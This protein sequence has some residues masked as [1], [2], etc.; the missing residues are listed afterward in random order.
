MTAAKRPARPI[1]AVVTD[2]DGTLTDVRRRLDPRAIEMIHRLVDRKVPVLLATGNVLPVALGIYRSLGLSTPIVAENGGILYRPTSRGDRVERLAD[3]AVALRAYRR[4]VRAGLPVRRLFTDRWRE[5]E[6]ALDT[7]VSVLRIEE[8]LRGFPIHVEG[9]G[10]A[11][12]LMERGTG[13]LPAL[14]R[15][16]TPLRL[17]PRDCVILG[18]GDNDIEMLRAAGWSVSFPNASPGARAAAT[19]LTRSDYTGGFIEG[20]KSSAVLSL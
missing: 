19:Y 10:F 12:H 14:V 1:R 17:A 9:T 20:V 11:I 8:A 7:R 16:L 6:V 13:K 3:P 2:I 15:A 18:D 4:L 5:S